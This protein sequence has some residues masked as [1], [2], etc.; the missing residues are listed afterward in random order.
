MQVAI[1]E[2]QIMWTFQH[3]ENGVEKIDC[4]NY[5]AEQRKQMVAVLEEALQEAKSYL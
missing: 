4:I 1:I 2:K 5:N 3:T